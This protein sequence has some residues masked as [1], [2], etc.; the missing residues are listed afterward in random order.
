MLVTLHEQFEISIGRQMELVTLYAIFS[1][2]IFTPFTPFIVVHNLEL[3]IAIVFFAKSATSPPP[4]VSYV[5]F[6]NVHA[7][8][9]VI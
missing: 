3:H 6:F 4:Q 2:H 9:Y 5:M 1:A 8:I 7:D